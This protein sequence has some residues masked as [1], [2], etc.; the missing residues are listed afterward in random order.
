MFCTKEGSEAWRI[1]RLR[2]WLFFLS[3]SSVAA[4]A[5]NGGGEKQSWTEVAPGERGREGG[6]ERLIDGG[7]DKDEE[8]GNE[9]EEDKTND[10]P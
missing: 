1:W 4:E 10:R 2:G 5:P 8:G 3:I 9:E 7:W 6:R